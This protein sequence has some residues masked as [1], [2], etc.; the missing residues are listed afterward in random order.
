[1]RT[2]QKHKVLKLNEVD[3]NEYI[4]LLTGQQNFELDQFIEK[5]DN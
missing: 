5:K 3:Y 1:M 4:K 2:K